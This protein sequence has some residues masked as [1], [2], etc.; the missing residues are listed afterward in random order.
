MANMDGAGLG[1]MRPKQNGVRGDCAVYQRP[2]APDSLFRLEVGEG[3][4]FRR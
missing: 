2:A 1:E 4:E 3:G